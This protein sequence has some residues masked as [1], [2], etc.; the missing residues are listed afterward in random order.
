M[1]SQHVISK[2]TDE[3]LLGLSISD[4][5]AI[6]DSPLLMSVLETVYDYVAIFDENLNL[7]DCSKS[8]MKL[9]HRDKAALVGKNIDVL[10]PEFKK[11]D[12]YEE[13]KIMCERKGYFEHDNYPIHDF[14]D[15]SNST[16]VQFKMLPKGNLIICIAE[17]ITVRI[18]YDILMQKYKK[19]MDKNEKLESLLTFS[20]SNSLEDS[21][22]NH[23]TQNDTLVVIL[24]DQKNLTNREI[25]VAMLI[26]QSQTTKEIADTLDVSI[27]TINFHRFNIRKKLE[28]TNSKIS[29]KAALLDL[30]HFDHSI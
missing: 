2:K 25:E 1:S 29:L 21:S 28:I 4:I 15:A 24:K 11:K 9:Y 12:L 17:N 14:E 26:I 7:L 19:L 16:Y 5:D 27:K 8:F 18:Q 30:Y 23:K 10:S 6:Q 3:S 13:F 20:N 22:V